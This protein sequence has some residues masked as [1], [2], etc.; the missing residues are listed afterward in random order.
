MRE[1]NVDYT[2]KFFKL[3]ERKIKKREKSVYAIKIDK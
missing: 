1:V 3:V 2:V